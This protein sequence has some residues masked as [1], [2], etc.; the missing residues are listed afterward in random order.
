MY[1]VNDYAAF[2]FIVPWLIWPLALLLL[3]LAQRGSC[4]QHPIYTSVDRAKAADYEAAVERVM[5]MSEEEMLSFLP[6]KNRI[7][8]CECPNCY[9]GSQG[10]NVL[11]WSIDAP[12]T[13]TCRYCGL[14]LK[15]PDERYPEKH[16]LTGQNALGERVEF[17][18]Y[19][20]EANGAKHYLSGHLSSYRR[21][22]LEQQCIALGKA[23]QA[24]GKAEYARRVVLVLDKAARLY[25]HYPA[26][27]SEHPR[28][29]RFCASQEPPYN[30]D[31]GRW[32]S[33]HHEI[34]RS[35]LLAYDL[36]YDSDQFDEM[37]R[38]F[39]YDVRARLET[40][41]LRPTFRAV[42]LS[43][44]HVGNVVGY[45]VTTAAMLGRVIGDPSMVHRAFGWIMQNLDEGFF[46]DG[47]WS[48]SPSYHYMT[49]GGLRGA[50]SVVKGYSDPPG[51]IDEID[52][53]RLD[54]LDPDA[55]IPF[56][57]K[58]QDAY[59]AI[60]FPNG[61][62][63]PVHDT[64]ANERR[65]APRTH[66]VSTILPGYGHAALG[67]GE[68]AAQMQAHLHFSGGYGHMHRDCL[69]LMLWARERE[70]L[71][72][73]GYTW[74]DIRWWNSSTI[75]H[76]LVA[77]D[78][79]EQRG[80][81]SDGD[82]LAF[83]PSDDGI[84]VVEAD[85]TRAYSNVEGLDTYR[86]LLALIPVTEQD[87]YV[88]DI[89]RTR[90]G[91]IHDWL[92]HGS[93]DDDMTAHC[94]LPADE[95]TGD[96]AEQEPPDTYKLWRNLQHAVADGDSSVTFTYDDRP[97]RGVRIHLLGTAPTD[98]YLGETPSIRR[99]GTG[100]A[101]DNRKTL[102]FWMPHLA[103]RR[104]GEAPLETLFAAVEEPF[105]GRPFLDGVRH[106]EV[107]PASDECV[108]MEVT[109]GAVSDTII[110]TSDERPFPARVAGEVTIAGRL[111]IVRR[112]D[113]KVTGMWLFDGRELTIGGHK[114]TMGD[115]AYTGT[116]E[117]VTRTADGAEHDA[118]ITAADL[119]VGEALR[120]TWMIVTHGNGFRHG[121]EIDH[122][123]KVDG[124]TAIILPHDHGLRIE[125]STTKEAFFPRRMIEGP[126]T[127][128]IPT[129]ASLAR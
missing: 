106:L 18:Y 25:P 118:F 81:P 64:W 51:Y 84:S 125:G 61:C 126:N 111:G 80:R 100:T 12:N 36:V 3:A 117:A 77:V 57:V 97:E 65:S 92:L 22:W 24:T 28:S 42:E 122:V 35:L 5:A 66:T 101:G 93:A 76:N 17:P 4:E 8:Y 105:D 91:S 74:T 6:E 79:Q 50:F 11:T 45:Q 38:E 73:L 54:N 47:T 43:A 53:T 33:F 96:F 119:P 10:L 123:A 60:D 88:V 62:S 26:L 19:L 31:A 52:G 1:G 86:R 108:A 13:L 128:R 2:R 58:V 124:R 75:S 110:C 89:S 40:D 30:W 20:N 56:W 14:V 99:A 63:P 7:P 34:P 44:Y 78:R 71:S 115:A 114:L 121:Y 98:L 37:S 69:S 104:T 103:A 129:R 59:K 68:G 83:F 127:F 23:Y 102:D 72:D 15:L 113:G 29:V 39:G 120:G 49:L 41:F 9:G 67:W 109:C 55:D 95:A 116:I 21:G 82:L 107:S 87:A 32:S 48:E 94:D 112:V 90:G 16:V 46:F 27:H 70:M 85:G